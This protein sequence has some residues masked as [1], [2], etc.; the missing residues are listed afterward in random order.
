[1]NQSQYDREEQDIID[2][3]NRGEI[4]RAQVTKEINELQREYQ[5]AAHEAAREAYNRELDNW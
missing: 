1:M 5:A 2:R 4:T 3:E